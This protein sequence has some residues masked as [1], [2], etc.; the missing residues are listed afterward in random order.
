MIVSANG[1]TVAQQQCR[2]PLK[3]FRM[4]L[5]A[6]F[7]MSKVIETKYPEIISCSAGVSS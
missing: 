7:M 3:F 2:Q 5:N 1:K 4:R 6:A